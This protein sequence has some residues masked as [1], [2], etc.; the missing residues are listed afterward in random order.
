MSVVE[1][2]FAVFLKMFFIVVGKQNLYLDHHLNNDKEYVYMLKIKWLLSSHACFNHRVP[3]NQMNTRVNE[4]THQVQ[5]E[6]EK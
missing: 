5:L 4:K 6:Q 2:F 1:P 3:K